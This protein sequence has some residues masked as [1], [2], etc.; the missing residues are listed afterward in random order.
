MKIDNI[1][2]EMSTEEFYQS[3]LYKLTDEEIENLNLWLLYDS[4]SYYNTTPRKE[5]WGELEY[6][7]KT[8]K[9]QRPSTLPQDVCEIDESS[10]DWKWSIVLSAVF[11]NEAPYL[12]EFI[13]FHKLMGVEHFFLYNNMT[14]VWTKDKSNENIAFHSFA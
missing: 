13:E 2:R 5:H 4:P 8:E 6:L 1:T 12:K 14:G 10:V 3:G 9:F 11:Q 7:Y